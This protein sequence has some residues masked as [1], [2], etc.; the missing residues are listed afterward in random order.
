MLLCDR[1]RT[2][3]ALAGE[4]KKLG[5]PASVLALPYWQA[6]RKRLGN[7]V[8]EIGGSV[9]YVLED[10]VVATASEA[11]LARPHSLVD[12]LGLVHVPYPCL[13]IEWTEAARLLAREAHGIAYANGKPVPHRLG[14]L[15]QT[16]EIGRRGIVKVA[17][18]FKL[19][20]EE[21]VLPELCPFVLHFDFDRITDDSIPD[22]TPEQQQASTY[23]ARCR[24]DAVQT[25]AIH[26]LNR[27]AWIEA[28]PNAQ[29]MLCHSF[30]DRTSAEVD[31][32]L[33]SSF[34]DVSAEGLF[35][36]AILTLLA[37]R[38]GVEMR[39]E[40]RAG[41]NKARRKRREPELLDHQ[42]AYLR[43][44]AAERAAVRTPG[45]GHGAPK[46]AHIVRGHFVRRSDKVYFRRAHWRGGAGGA[47]AIKIVK[48]SL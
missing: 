37:A 9:R 24:G 26:R 8:G 48:V 14:Y 19:G 28:D 17:W 31:Q 16:D 25:A 46:R 2:T 44:T 15:I 43:L 23:Y 32:V 38:N 7:W 45:T 47:A 11:L 36:L 21:E 4:P 18:N 13:W 1:I 20:G 12:V 10:A 6:M 5:F 29:E 30:G 42:I 41:I 39:Q 27:V 33:A 3:A 35:L 40:S 34:E 22:A